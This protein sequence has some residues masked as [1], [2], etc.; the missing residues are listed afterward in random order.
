MKYIKVLVFQLT[1]IIVG[2]DWS[3]SCL[4]SGTTDDGTFEDDAVRILEESLGQFY[5]QTVTGLILTEDNSISYDFLLSTDQANENAD[6]VINYT[7]IQNG[8]EKSEQKVEVAKRK[9]FAVRR[10]RQSVFTAGQRHLSENFT[11]DLN[12]SSNYFDNG[13]LEARLL[14]GISPLD[15]EDFLQLIRHAQ[16]TNTFNRDG[17][18]VISSLHSSKGT[19]TFEFAKN[20]SSYKIIEIRIDKNKANEIAFVRQSENAVVGSFGDSTNKLNSV[21]FVAKFNWRPEREANVAE[22]DFVVETFLSARFENGVTESQR[23]TI[24]VNSVSETCSHRFDQLNFE[25]FDNLRAVPVEVITE[26]FVHFRLHDSTIKKAID[27]SALQPFDE[28][29]HPGQDSTPIQGIEGLSAFR[30]R[31]YTNYLNVELNNHC[32]LY[33]S[34]IALAETGMAVDPFDVISGKYLTDKRGSTPGDLWQIFEDYQVSSHYSE[35]MSISE[36][37]ISKQPILLLLEMSTSIEGPMH[38]ILF[39]GDTN[40]KAE[41]Y[42]PSSQIRIVEYRELLTNWRGKGVRVGSPERSFK[43]RIVSAV[44][45]GS[46]GL[47]VLTVLLGTV[48]IVRS[49]HTPNSV[50]IKRF[51]KIRHV[52]VLFAVTTLVAGTHQCFSSKSFVGAR[53]E[54]SM[55]TSDVAN[56]KIDAVEFEEISSI[57]DSVV[58]IDARPQWSFFRGHIE[59]AINVPVDASVFELRQKINAIPINQPVVVYCQNRHCDW[60]LVVARRLIKCGIVGVSVYEGGWVEWQ[61]RNGQ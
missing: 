15:S 38:W 48:F 50:A 52:G 28:A 51:P 54:L 55:L 4:Y 12:P 13:L 53:V 3:S 16:L 60:D 21:A 42:D 5:G 45:F 29:P 59:G 61:E 19:Y 30:D 58:F 11:A 2:S 10:N 23:R 57:R 9:T 39:L 32:G 37:R 24:R 49:I 7:Y 1:L 17:N 25:G 35:K 40:G 8:G 41:I 26:P 18:L 31:I 6:F 47:L 22:A 20:G 56:A 44:E 36:L 43:E 34:I 33:C 14:F 27:F 46:P